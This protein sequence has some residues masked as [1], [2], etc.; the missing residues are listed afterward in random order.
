[1]PRPRKKTT[2]KTILPMTV[3]ISGSL[4]EAA[5]LKSLEPLYG[6]ITMLRKE[7]VRLQQ[8]VMGSI[9]VQTETQVLLKNLS[10]QVLRLLTQQTQINQFLSG[11]SKEL[12]AGDISSKSAQPKTSLAQLTEGLA[13]LQTSL[14]SD[15]N[16]QRELVHSLAK[17][18]QSL[19]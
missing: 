1:M 8:Q 10:K 12:A 3:E 15:I 18:R 19:K 14:D 16:S 9:T 4:L 2:Q 13:N 5:L 7:N 6:E 11:L 17:L